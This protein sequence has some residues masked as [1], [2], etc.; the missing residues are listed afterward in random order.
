[1]KQKDE[2]INQ[3]GHDLKN[4]LTPLVNLLPIIEEKEKDTESKEL[5]GVINRN[6]GYMKNL[7]TKTIELARLNSSNTVFNFEDINLLSEMN[8][9]IETNKLLFEEKGI[10]VVNNVPSDIQVSVDRLR[11]EELLNNILNNSIKYTDSTDS[12]GT[13]TI[14]A[15]SDDSFVTVSVSDTGIG[16]T[17]EQLSHV[18]DEFYKADSSRH[19]FYSSGLGMAICKRIV[20][21][22]GGQIWAESKGEGKGS[23]FYF[24]IPRKENVIKKQIDIKDNTVEKAD[25]QILSDNVDMLDDKM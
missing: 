7:V 12:E 24:T 14:D 11:I 5:L 17:C 16:M 20:E 9:V 6:V 21:K 2:F 3:L 4:P 1:M 22:H 15:K 25:K 18:F 10:H 8:K 19:D 13:I 23:I